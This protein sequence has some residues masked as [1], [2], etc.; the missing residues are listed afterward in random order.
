[1]RKRANSA[2]IPALSALR[3]GP[4]QHGGLGDARTTTTRSR[5]GTTTVVVHDG[6]PA[7]AGPPPPS[8]PLSLR[9]ALLLLLGAGYGILVTRLHDEHGPAASAAATS[10][11]HTYSPTYLASWGALG[12]MLGLLLP[13]FDAVWART[14]GAAAGSADAKARAGG[15]AAAA[16]TTTTD[17]ALVV[18]GIGAFV[19]IVFAIVSLS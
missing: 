2:S 10:S 16:T 14:F 19:G 4:V 9:V 3:P 5:T 15:G 11:P 17:W 1:M 7:A 12:V 8:T 6:T 13:W 18:R